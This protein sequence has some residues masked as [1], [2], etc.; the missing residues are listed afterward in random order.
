MIRILFLI[1]I[2]SI[3]MSNCEGQPKTTGDN[4]SSVVF[5]SDTVNNKVD[6]K[7]NGAHFTSYIYDKS[8]PKPVLF[9]LITSSGKTLTRGFPIDPKPGERVD[10]PHHMGHWFNYGDVNGLDFWNNSDAIPKEKIEN[11]GKIVHSEIVDISEENGSIKTKSEWQTINGDPILEETTVFVFSQKGDTRII[12]RRTNLVAITDVSFDD[13]KEGVFGVRVTR[14]MELPSKKPAIFVDAQGNP[15]EVKVLDNTGVNGNYLSS[16]GLEGNEVWGTRSEWVKLY[17]SMDDEPVSIT[18]IDHPN[19]VG[20]PTYWHA[21]D[22]GLFS[23][24]PLGQKVFSKGEEVLNFSLNKGES[25]TFNHRMLIHSGSVLKAEKIKEFTFTEDMYKSYFDGS[26]LSNWI[27][28]TRRGEK[29]GTIVSEVNNN[30][31]IWWSIEDGN[32]RVKSGPEEKGSTLWTRDEFKNFRVRLK[33][34]FVD[35]NIDSGVF[36]RGSD[37]FNPQIQIG[38]SGS[39]K[40]DMTGSPYIPKKGYPKE[41]IKVA[42]LLKMNDWNQMEAEAIENK[43]RVWFNG[44]FVMDYE[45]EE[46]N[47]N[48]PVGI[49]LHSN[50]NMEILYKDIDIASF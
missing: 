25:T 16:R 43:Y 12:D 1:S 42:D 40:R 29:K 23:A 28:K 44:V 33:F 24:N 20:Y 11:Y 15:T 22:Y 34:K 17:S 41:A 30:D 13:N 46:G 50:R 18:I 2:L 32:L 19:N 45:L 7:I 3:T 48:G 47:L 21:R 36:M 5:I 8:L 4:E 9:P 38:V 49:Q 35:G 37:E 14:A 27:I 10:H 26:D 6:V 39:L 31:N